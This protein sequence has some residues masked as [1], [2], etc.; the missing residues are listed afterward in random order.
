MNSEPDNVHAKIAELV[1]QSAAFSRDE[2]FEGASKC[3]AEA[4]ELSEIAEDHGAA[5]CHYLGAADANFRAMLKGFPKG[6]EA[7]AVSCVQHAEQLI[8]SAAN[9]LGGRLHLSES[10]FAT[11]AERRLQLAYWKEK[12]PAPPVAPVVK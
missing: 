8:D 2:D 10:L 5:A 9:V 3:R 4:A 12:H 7:V 1:E 11:L 6:K